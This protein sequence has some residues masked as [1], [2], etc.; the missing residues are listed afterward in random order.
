MP[1][2]GFRFATHRQSHRYKDAVVHVGKPKVTCHTWR[3]KKTN[4][5]Q[6]FHVDDFVQ[7]LQKL[8][9]H[10]PMTMAFETAWA[11]ERK[12]PTP[13]TG[14]WYHRQKDHVLGWFASQVT[15]GGGAYTRAKPNTSARTTYNRLLNP[16]MPLWIAEALGE[17]PDV[18]QQAGEKALTVPPRSRTAAAR[19][20][21]PWNRIVELAN[22]LQTPQSPG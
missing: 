3:M 19:K 13:D 18:V 2:P 5:S 16:A 10:Q 4:A 11:V 14:Q 1:S 6:D 22:A 9:G 12:K 8:P 17:D 15:R 20:I 7:I 21:L